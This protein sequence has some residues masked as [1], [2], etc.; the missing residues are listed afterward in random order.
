MLT[1]PQPGSDGQNQ[2]PHPALG[3]LGLK[4]RPF[5]PRFRPPSTDPKSAPECSRHRLFYS[6][7]LFVNTAFVCRFT[8]LEN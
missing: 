6:Q 8:V 5:G 2:E 1:L 7:L 3:P 4:L